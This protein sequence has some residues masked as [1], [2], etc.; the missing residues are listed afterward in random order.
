MTKPVRTTPSHEPMRPARAGA[1]RRGA[2]P[3]SAGFGALFLQRPSAPAVRTPPQTTQ[4]PPLRA[5]EVAELEP[6]PSALER[7]APVERVPE[8]VV[9]PQDSRERELA[10]VVAATAQPDAPLAQP[11]VFLH[12]LS[13]VVEFAAL[14]K[15]ARGAHHLQLGVTTAGAGAQ[16]SYDIQLTALGEGRIA[17]KV[18]G[19]GVKD[20]VALEA[21]RELVRRLRDRGLEVLEDDETR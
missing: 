21:Q 3:V 15:D 20:R 17:L 8:C 2:D 18:R 4:C 11:L 14:V 13:E 5:V 7:E 10:L 19:V 12:T 6:R 9:A 16:A 1:A